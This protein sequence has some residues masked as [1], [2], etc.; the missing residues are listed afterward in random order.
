M[1]NPRLG[2]GMFILVIA[3]VLPASGGGKR[4]KSCRGSNQHDFFVAYRLGGCVV[5]IMQL[6]AL[7]LFSAEKT[8]EI[9]RKEERKIQDHEEIARVLQGCQAL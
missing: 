8:V 5:P 1:K 6:Q 7:V 4:K 9:V 2:R 3:G